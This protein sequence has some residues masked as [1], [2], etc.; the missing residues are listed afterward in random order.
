MKT[1]ANGFHYLKSSLSPL[2]NL[3]ITL[4]NTQKRTKSNQN[5]TKTGSVVNVRIIA[6]DW[7][8]PFELMCD[9]SDFAI[10]EVLG[11][12]QDK[13]FRPIHYASNGYDKKG[14]KSKQIQTKPSTKQK[15]WKSQQS[16]VNKDKIKAKET[17]KSKGKQS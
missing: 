2:F 7:D 6:P 10:V 11:Q 16:K 15:A 13:H 4:K 17:K 12:R 1:L 14:T 9:T 8:M 3:G 5:W